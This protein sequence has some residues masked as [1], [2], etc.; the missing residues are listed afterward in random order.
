MT[1]HTFRRA[2]VRSGR[3][4]ATMLGHTNASFTIDNY[5]PIGDEGVGAALDILADAEAV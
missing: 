2:R 1:F 5:C 3:Q 4:I